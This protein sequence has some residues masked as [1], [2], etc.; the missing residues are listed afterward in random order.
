MNKEKILDEAA[1]CLGCKLKPCSKACP[2]HTN[3]PEFIE[4]IKK[5]N[6]EE[7]YNILIQNNLFSH[8]CSLVC[9]QEEQCEGSC[10]RGIKQTPTKI[11]FLEKSVNEWALE[12]NIKPKIEILNKNYLK[13]VA[14]IG[15]GPARAF[16]CL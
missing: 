8:V 16:L 9:P 3:I 14:I 12:N 15:S 4:K 6:F 13:K 10:I 11:G 1:W 5:N 7:S 2:M